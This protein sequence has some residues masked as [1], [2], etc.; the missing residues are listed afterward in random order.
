M[1]SRSFRI[2]LCLAALLWVA[3]TSS[4]AADMLQSRVVRIVD[5]DTLTLLVSEPDGQKRQTKIRLAG[6]APESRQPWGMKAKQALSGYVFG[7]DV[8]V[9]W[10][11][12]DRY[13][14]TVGKVLDGERDVNLA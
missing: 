5:G 9:E 1:A 14:R 3:C 8:A 2:T 13:G 4:A 11:K 12:H 7:R 6:D 10:S